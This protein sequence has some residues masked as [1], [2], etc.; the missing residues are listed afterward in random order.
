MSAQL[1]ASSSLPDLLTR[2]PLPVAAALTE[3]EERLGSMVS[4]AAD[5]VIGKIYHSLLASGGKRLRPLLTLL[6]CA[7][8]GGEPPQAVA[9]AM[10]IEVLHLASLIHDDVIDDSDERRGRP[11]AQRRWGNRAAILAGDYLVAEVFRQTADEIAHETVAT[12]A[13]AVAEMCRAELM[14][15]KNGSES[16][17]SDYIALISGKTGALMAAA[18]EAGALA[19]DNRLAAQAL[20]PFGRYLGE[21]FQI[22]DD[23]L[24]LYGDPEVMGK[25]IHQDLQRGDWTLPVLKA[26][27]NATPSAAA[28]LRETLQAAQSS[29]AAAVTAACLVDQLGGRVYAAAEAADRISLGLD[30]L[31]QLPPTPSRTLLTELAEGVL[32][33]DK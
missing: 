28:E 26:L 30:C 5:G 25:P 13:N 6:S 1:P 32:N 11:A 22:T 7:A 14:D 16:A 31:Q 9:L 33:R 20:R 17:R 24:D 23:L 4:P 2:L 27:E 29:G 3:V 19:A 8:S 10:G 18:C 15:Q 12:L 21:A